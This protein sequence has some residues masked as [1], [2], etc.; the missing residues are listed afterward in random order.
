MGGVIDTVKS[1]FRG[2]KIPKQAQTPEPDP[3]PLPDDE[4]VRASQR[5][6]LARQRQR[7]GRLSTILSSSNRLGG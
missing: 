4:S 6:S 2:P 1:I 7:G 5:Q 3:A